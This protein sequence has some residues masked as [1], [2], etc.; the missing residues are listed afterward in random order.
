MGVIN[1]GLRLDK[2]QTVFYLQD[3]QLLE[4]MAARVRIAPRG[5][6]SSCGEHRA[7]A[8]VTHRPH[9]GCRG[10]TESVMFPVTLDATLL[11]DE[12]AVLL[13]GIPVDRFPDGLYEAQV[14]LLY[15]GTESPVQD[16]VLLEVGEC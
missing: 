6:L 3:V 7:G 2:P 15:R 11:R 14:I 8:L 5:W 16:L 10:S 13:E 4:G 12:V 1:E 9:H